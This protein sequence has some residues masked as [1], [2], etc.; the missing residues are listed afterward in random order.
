MDKEKIKNILVK[1]GRTIHKYIT[2]IFDSLAACYVAFMGVLGFCVTS[3]CLPIMQAFTA[4]EA[5]SPSPEYNLILVLVCMVGL[6]FLCLPF[7]YFTLCW[8][9]AE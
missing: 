3:L 1:F 2:I 8:R 9:S 7:M 5:I 4:G 6:L